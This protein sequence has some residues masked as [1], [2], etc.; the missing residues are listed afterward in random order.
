MIDQVSDDPAGDIARA[1]KAIN[2]ALGLQPENSSAH[3]VKGNLYFA[4]QQWGPTITEEETAIALD[5][6]NARA[7][8][9]ASLG[10]MFRGH[11]EDGIAGVETAL[12]L[13][14]HPHVPWW[15]FDMCALQGNL[16][17]DE[18]AISGATRPP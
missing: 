16:A 8:A 5:P 7:Y 15:Q 13:S 18:Q 11:A 4:K 3:Y 17:H 6:N 2:T 9:I 14:P 12:R 10:K 1:E